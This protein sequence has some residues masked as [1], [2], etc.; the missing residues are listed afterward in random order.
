MLS[1]TNSLYFPKLSYLEQVHFGS[2]SDS[3]NKNSTCSLYY[4]DWSLKD[5]K[6]EDAHLK[7]LCQYHPDKHCPF[8]PSLP[9]DIDMWIKNMKF[10]IPL[11]YMEEIRRNA[12]RG[13]YEWDIYREF[14]TSVREFCLNPA[15]SHIYVAFY[16]IADCAY[17][18]KENY[19][20]RGDDKVLIPHA[21]AYKFWAH[22]TGIGCLAEH[23]DIDSLRNWANFDDTVLSH[24]TKDLYEK[25]NV[26]R[27]FLEKIKTH[28]KKWEEQYKL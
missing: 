7:W 1:V 11:N 12:K 21:L 27:E 15:I 5:Q 25:A 8:Y 2:W 23:A 10:A 28:E 16:L 4:L 3:E 26:C 20:Y 6:C 9:E 18:P 24:S 17:D 14:D 19:F 22:Q 13:L